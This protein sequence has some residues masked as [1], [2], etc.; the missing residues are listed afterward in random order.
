MRGMSDSKKRPVWPW[1]VGLVTGFPVL[2]VL[3]FGPA[4]W[5]AGDNEQGQSAVALPSSAKIPIRAL[6]IPPGALAGDALRT[7]L[8]AAQRLH[9]NALVIDFKDP[10]GQIAFSKSVTGLDGYPEYSAD[11][12]GDTPLLFSEAKK[13][14]LYLIARVVLFLDTSLSDRHPDW[15]IRNADGTLYAGDG[16]TEKFVSPYLDETWSYNAEAARAAARMGFD[17]VQFDYVR[18]PDDEGLVYPGKPASP[19]L[20]SDTIAKGVRKLRSSLPGSLTVSADVFGRTVLEPDETIGQDIV[21]LAAEVDVVCP[22][23]YPSLWTDG[24]LDL[25]H[26]PA[27]PFKTIY[28]SLA[29]LERLLGGKI[30]PGKIRPWLQIGKWPGAN[31][32]AAETDAELRAACAHGVDGWMLWQTDGE[33]DIPSPLRSCP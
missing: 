9:A 15:A 13:R 29:A 4:G 27:E 20:R 21:K 17:E 22:M 16:G 5:I 23:L 33:Y 12:L 11:R 6:Y 30:P 19:G 18:F 31:Y 10:S 28:L 14:G 7:R 1:M 26:P 8:D 32:G 24:S 2:C 25:P 3:L